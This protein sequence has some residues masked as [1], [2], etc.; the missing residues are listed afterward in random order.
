MIS[1]QLIGKDGEDGARAAFEHLVGQLVGL[2]F[3]GMRIVEANPGDWGLDVI[4]GE[5]DGVVSVWQAKF[6]INGISDSQK[7]QIRES[8]DQVVKKAAEKGFTIDAWILC[9]PCNL[10]PDALKWWTKWKKAKEKATG[11]SIELDD[12]ARLETHL[13][14]PE[15]SAILRHYFPAL[16][17]VLAAPLT[18]QELPDDVYYEDMLFVKQLAAAQIPET[19]S[20]KQAFFNAEV[21]SREVADKR[22]G[23][24]IDAL[25]AERADLR[26]IWEDR[27]NKTCAAIDPKHDLL[28][29]LHPDVVEAI[30]HRHDGAGVGVLPMH[31]IHRK[32]A[33]HQVV[34]DGRAGWVRDYRSVVE[35]HRG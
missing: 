7:K 2:R 10:H 14:A 32:G 27:Y 35:A 28:P 4:V 22:V 16:A 5:L 34:E 18:V 8:F 20:A 13:L 3:S 11:I 33:M 1:F 21:L 31:L 15:A 19:E 24:H 6:F 30:E 17:P 23:E 29:D 9:V 12:Q 26:S 25:R